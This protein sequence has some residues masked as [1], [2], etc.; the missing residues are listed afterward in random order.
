MLLTLNN[1][2]RNMIKL[3]N[4]IIIPKIKSAVGM[5]ILGL[6]C[7][8]LLTALILVYLM[9]AK[10]ELDTQLLLLIAELFLPI[11]IIYW[12]KRMRTSLGEL[13]RIRAVTPSSLLAAVFVAIGLTV[14]IDELD[15]LIQIVLPLPE[16]IIQIG[17]MMKVTNWQ[18]AFLVIG[19]VVL[20]TPLIEEVMF[21]G[22][23]QRILEYRQ[24]DITKS[25]LISAMVFAMIHFNPWWIVQIYM[26][27]LFM[28]YMAWR[29]NSIWPSFVLHA[30]N[31]GWSVW[32][33]HEPKVAKLWEWHGHVNP[34][35]LAAGI[36]C[37][38]VSMR[39]FIAVTPVAAK[40]PDVVLIENLA[41][42]YNTWIQVLSATTDTSKKYLIRCFK[43][44]TFSWSV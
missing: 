9:Q 42:Y 25:V 43:S 33:A 11:P 39:F 24:G 28:G 12:A 21:R 38:Y 27:G 1:D 32:W 3:K 18:S 19:I 41:D 10:Q 20:A 17:E 14:I 6:L 15:R 40:R 4:P 36:L 35:I 37:F 30:I 16:N 29:T 22:F 2:G 23:F 13:L 31:N 7:A 44:K 34:I 26:M 8:S 5:L